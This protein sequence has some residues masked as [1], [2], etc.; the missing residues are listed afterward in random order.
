M[1]QRVAYLAHTVT[2]ADLV[3]GAGA[4]TARTAFECWR[5]RWS[6]RAERWE[7]AQWAIRGFGPSLE[8]ALAD[9]L[10]AEHD[11]MLR[12]GVTG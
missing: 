4:D 12:E 7:G 5:E 1:R 8:T 2:M 6:E 10:R 9:L 11:H 3:H